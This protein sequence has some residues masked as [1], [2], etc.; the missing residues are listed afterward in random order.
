VQYRQQQMVLSVV[1]GYKRLF[2][3]HLLIVQ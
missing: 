2:V 1:S 3:R